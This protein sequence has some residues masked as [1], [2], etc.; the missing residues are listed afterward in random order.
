MGIAKGQVWM[1]ILLAVVLIAATGSESAQAQCTTPFTLTG[2]NGGDTFGRAVSGI[3]DVNGD[4]YDDFIVGA[5]GNG[6]G[7]PDAGRA[8]VY[9]GLTGTR[10]YLFTGEEEN[11]N[12]G[13]SVSG[14]GDVNGDG[15]PDFI[16]GTRNAG[17]TGKAYVY[18]GADG[19]ELYT[20]VGADAGDNL[21]WGVNDA[22]DVDGDG[23]DDVIV[24]A[25]SAIPLAQP[26][27]A[28]VFSGFDGSVIHEFNGEAPEDVFGRSVC[29]IGDVDGDGH[30][31][32]AVAAANNDAG[33]N[34]AGR[35]YVYSGDDGSLLY[36]LTGE[37]RGH[38]F[39][40]EIAGVGDVNDD[41]IPDLAVGAPGA[42]AGRV[43]VFEG[44]TGNLIYVANG[45]IPGDEFGR[46]VAGCGDLNGDHIPD[47]I[48]GARGNDIA[49]NNAGRAYALL[50]HNGAF[51]YTFTGDG[52]NRALGTAVSCAG[53]VNGDGIDDILLS[54][55]R[56][57]PGAVY[58]HACW[59][60]V[61]DVLPGQCPN[62]ISEED[63]LT[64][65]GS[66]EFSP[67]NRSS[68]TAGANPNPSS[69]VSI[70]ILGH[71]S[72]D[73]ADIDAASVRVAGLAPLTARLRDVAA[74][75]V[76]ETPCDCGS[77]GLDGYTD[78]LLQYKKADLI[79]ALGGDGLHIVAFTGAMQSGNAVAG[80]DCLTISGGRSGSTLAAGSDR[81][82]VASLSCYPNPF[83]AATVISYTLT[84]AG[85][86]RLEVYNVTGQKV[87]TLADEFQSPGTHQITWDSRD[88]YARDVA[89]GVYLFRLTTEKDVE[90]IKMLLLK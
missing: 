46:S 36:T 14:A 78:L 8:Y 49:G 52:N 31:D 40:F 64:L 10:L 39:G 35:V 3:G 16:I 85:P 37:R 57:G 18:S 76:R 72:F 44:H 66:E 6:A 2:Q 43:Y 19:S 67:E 5:S 87:T 48:V 27:K 88:D 73:V 77:L 4:G 90:S 11:D 26:G 22:G 54:G 59:P 84:E 32:V 71:G 21:G 86:V 81:S 23:Y 24:G 68:L 45:E 34:N 15:T 69:S 74:F 63:L 61:L 7:G 41:G 65:D 25:P 9:S 82:R 50:G 17:G 47:V 79:A 70:A 30:A 20:F 58:V 60:Q 28:Y 53:D 13:W 83:N 42:D 62:V 89:S 56:R 75:P 51:F 29:G 80:T 12:L 33:G 38:N 1:S 55:P